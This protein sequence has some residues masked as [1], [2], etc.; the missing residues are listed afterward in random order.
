MFFKFSSGKYHRLEAIEAAD[1][2]GTMVDDITPKDAIDC[3]GSSTVFRSLAPVKSLT[4]VRNATKS[5]F[6]A[7]KTRE[8][9]LLVFVRWKSYFMRYRKLL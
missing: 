1:E 3:T 9:T 5:L 4:S 6:L 7:C 2:P 8:I